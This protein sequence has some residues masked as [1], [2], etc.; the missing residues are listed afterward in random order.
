MLIEYSHLLSLHLH[1]LFTYFFSLLDM[2]KEGPPNTTDNISGAPNSDN[3]ASATSTN[4][5]VNKSDV[6]NNSVSSGSSTISMSNQTIQQPPPQQQQPQMQQP[7][8]R[9]LKVE[10]AL[11]YLDQV[12]CE[13]SEYVYND[14]LEIMKNFKNQS[15][16]TPGVIERVKNLFK[17]TDTLIFSF[18][19]SLTR[20]L[21]QVTTS[22]FSV[23][24][25]FYQKVKD[26]R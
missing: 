20:L 2:D 8:N 19:Q 24:I 26:I 16:S 1:R 22:L 15:I 10:D 18:N 13:C 9:E 4:A 7:K 5:T 12:K 11:L 25:H 14:F 23:S 21:R 6:Y 17:G 3:G